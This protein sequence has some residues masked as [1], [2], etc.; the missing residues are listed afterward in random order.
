MSNIR[1]ETFR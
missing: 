1:R